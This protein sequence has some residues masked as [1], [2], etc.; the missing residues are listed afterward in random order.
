MSHF[1]GEAQEG[2]APSS[3]SA[4]RRSSVQHTADLSVRRLELEATPSSIPASFLRLK[5][6]SFISRLHLRTSSRVAEAQP[7]RELLPD[8]WMQIWALLITDPDDAVRDVARQ[9]RQNPRDPAPKPPYDLQ[10]T[11]CIAGCFTRCHSTPPP[12]A[13][14]GLRQQPASHPRPCA[15]AG[16]AAP[17]RYGQQLE[18]CQGR[19]A[20][21]LRDAAGTPSPHRSV[22]R[23]NHTVGSAS[24]FTIP[25]PSSISSSTH[26]R[27][28]CRRSHSSS[29]GK[30]APLW[31]PLW[32]EPSPSWNHHRRR[33]T[34]TSVSTHNRTGRW[35]SRR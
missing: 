19:G 6:R 27:P 22:L 14:A 7:A 32:Q 25:P 15:L 17:E 11:P 18:H 28:R 21:P 24:S 34:R 31:W 26:P 10:R 4:R 3:P 35:S 2:L 9:A 12:H 29:R 13:A 30:A 16:R 20:L 8:R 1:S 5:L 23:R 33:A